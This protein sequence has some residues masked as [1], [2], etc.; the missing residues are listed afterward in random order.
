MLKKP[1]VSEFP[2]LILWQFYSVIILKSIVEFLLM[3]ARFYHGISMRLR[4]QFVLPINM[5]SS[6]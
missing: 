3:Q 4:V 1:Q 5:Y 6:S 2:K